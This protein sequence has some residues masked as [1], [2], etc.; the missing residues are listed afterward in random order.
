[1]QVFN[2]EVKESMPILTDLIET[3]RQGNDS[4]NV[5][6][7]THINQADMQS[8]KLKNALGVSQGE[9]PK[10]LAEL[11]I[12]SITL[13]A[14]F[15]S[16]TLAGYN[17]HVEEGEAYRNRWSEIKSNQL[18]AD[19]QELFHHCHTVA[20]DDWANVT[21][22][23]E[24]WDGLLVDV[25]RP[26][27]KL[28]LDFIFYLG[29]PALKRSFQI[30]EILDILSDFS[31]HGR[32]TVAMDETE[33]VKLWKM[34]NAEQ[35]SQEPVTDLRRKSVFIY[36]TMGVDRLLVYAADHVILYSNDTQFSMIRQ[37][38]AQSVE[39]R[40]DARNIF[41]A[42][43]SIGLLLRLS[44]PH[45]IALGLIVFGAQGTGASIPDQQA[46]LDYID[47]WID[48]LNKPDTHIYL[49]Q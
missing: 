30:D 23:S 49:Y 46:L 21:Q 15:N 1:M 44:M 25:M 29:D 14:A 47:Q 39:Y 32:V 40:P 17:F 9:L 7:S 38:V 31:R 27:G 41:I 28:D 37:V 42:G 16:G 48:E 18:I 3:I 5:Y 22:A 26:L 19:L 36:R 8:G 10:P 20:F 35:F 4:H 43:F 6:L 11:G 33:A 24:L 34:L 2:I 12:R 45:C 13:N